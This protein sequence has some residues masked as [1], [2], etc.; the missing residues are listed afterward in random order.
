[1]KS[2]LL[3]R[4]L[5]GRELRDTV[6]L[7]CSTVSFGGWT[8]SPVGLDSS[9]VVFSLGVANDI[10]FDKEIIDLC[11]CNVHAFDPT[12]RWVDWIRTQQTPDRFHFHPFAVGGKDGM[13]RMYPRMLKGKK[14]STMLTLVDEGAGEGIA[15][16]VQ[17]KRISTIMSELGIQHIDLL[18]MDIEASEYE[19]IDDFL[20]SGIHVYQL[21]VEFHHRFKSVPI[22]RTRSVV[23][24]LQKAGYRIFHISD[25]YREFAFIHEA[26]LKSYLNA[27]PS[28]VP[29]YP[30]NI[31]LPEPA[32]F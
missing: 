3:F 1:M 2:K 14:S 24:R 13:I 19:V 16:D 17:V 32:V 29:V 28:T 30:E 27:C 12:P 6:D 22:E 25:K 10:Q 26:S 4:Q 23:H 15:V 7:V 11:S 9:S 5:T 18:K 8:F 21:I 20:D 31:P